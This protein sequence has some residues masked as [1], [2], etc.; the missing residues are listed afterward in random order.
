MRYHRINQH[1]SPPVAYDYETLS[2]L[3][4][5]LGYPQPPNGTKFEIVKDADGESAGFDVEIG[6]DGAYYYKDPYG[7]GTRVEVSGLAAQIDYLEEI[8]LIQ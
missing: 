6:H 2:A 3:T 8:D 7:T 4:S 1:Q 5:E